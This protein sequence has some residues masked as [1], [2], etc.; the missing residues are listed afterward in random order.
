MPLA[1]EFWHTAAMARVS[2]F[3]S[4]CGAVGRV[5]GV[6][7]WTSLVG[8][9]VA[10]WAAGV[11]ARAQDADITTLHVYANTIQIPVLVLGQD[12]RKIGPI[13]SSRFNVSFDGGPP[14][15]ASHV[16]LEG[17]D[18]I[19][20][21]ILLDVSG[22]QAA[23][24]PKVDNAIAKLASLSL[25][26]QDHVS[27][28][29]LDCK[30]TRSAENVVVSPELLKDAVARSLQSWRDRMRDRHGAGCQQTV[31]LWDALGYITNRLAGQPGRRV[32]LALT[33]GEDKGSSNRWNQVRIFAQMTAVAIF[34][35]SYVPNEPG[36]L[37]SLNAPVF[38]QS[39]SSEDAFHSVCELSGGLVF[40]A[41]N[42]TLDKR[43]K[44]FVA[45]VR[46]RYI[47][48]FPRP[49]NSTRGQHQFVVAIDKSKAFIRSTGI[50][51]PL[52]DAKVL[53]DPS[54]VRSDPSLA[55]EE[56]TRHILETPQ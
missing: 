9:G 11:M 1:T 24:M 44:E 39:L 20:L 32:I 41:N 23:L 12:R 30:L 34:G 16:R 45:M 37:Q 40:A 4:G 36:F 15:R 33:D 42:D 56:G 18:P 51:V 25:R 13:A 48:E 21:A 7:V 43:L 38:S 14:F 10:A 28:Y 5:A 49:Y 3:A 52:Q 19:S 8:L 46:G 6:C 22:P 54:T 50:S 35:M 2:G 26:P 17:D 27:V 29:A 53:A 47:V 55:P 31:H